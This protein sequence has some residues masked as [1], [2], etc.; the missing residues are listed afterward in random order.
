MVPV[1]AGAQ[2][3]RNKLRRV[4]RLHEAAVPQN[5]RML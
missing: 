1:T 4:S 3:G 2:G 5:A